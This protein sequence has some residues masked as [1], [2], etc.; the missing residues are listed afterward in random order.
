MREET[1]KKSGGS[2]AL[3]KTEKAEVNLESWK[4]DGKKY[5]FLSEGYLNGTIAT[6][7]SIKEIRQNTEDGSTIHME[8]DLRNTH[9][10]YKT[11][12]NLGIYVENDPA[13]VDKLGN[14]MNLDLNERV[15][16]IVDA[17]KQEKFKY[18]FPSPIAIKTILTQFCDF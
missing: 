2:F 6:V 8:I 15:E 5:E 4:H 7:K 1:K 3:V 17:D 9:L 18:P 16:I 13:F 14:Y 10:K 11:A 12:Q